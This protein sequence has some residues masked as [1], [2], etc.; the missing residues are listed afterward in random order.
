VKCV[1]A[2]DSLEQLGQRAAATTL[3]FNPTEEAV[4]IRTWLVSGLVAFPGT[5]SMEM[6]RKLQGFL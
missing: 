5:M 4:E 6:R 1:L 3:L 2:F